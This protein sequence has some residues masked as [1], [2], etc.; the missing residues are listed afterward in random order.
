MSKERMQKI[1]VKEK[2]GRG[3]VANAGR[4]AAMLCHG[5]YVLTELMGSHPFSEI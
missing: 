5:R 2:L 4:R 3:A 1:N